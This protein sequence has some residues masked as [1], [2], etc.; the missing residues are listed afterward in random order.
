MPSSVHPMG[1][2]T[3]FQGTS[4]RPSL[5]HSARASR[6]SLSRGALLCSC[7]SCGERSVWEARSAWMAATWDGNWRTEMTLAPS[8][9]S[10]SSRASI[11]I[12]SP[13]RK[14]RLFRNATVGGV[15]PR[16]AVVMSPRS[17]ATR[18]APSD[19]SSP[20]PAPSPPLSAPTARDSSRSAAQADACRS[21]A[22]S[23]PRAALALNCSAACSTMRPTPEPRSTTTSPGPVSAAANTRATPVG[24]ISPYV[25]SLQAAGRSPAW[26]AT[27]AMRS[28]PSSPRVN[29]AYSPS[30]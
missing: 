26:E 12:M 29:P 11:T 17:M 9:R 30:E 19:M 18:R 7:S 27:A 20:A 15:G 22:N 16:S 5:A 1:A 2:C 21:S 13:G 10:R 8:G 24:R 25:A 28:R 14:Q 4:R 3:T 6:A 23:T